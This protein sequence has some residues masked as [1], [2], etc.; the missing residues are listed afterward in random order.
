MC[1]PAAE[2]FFCVFFSQQIQTPHSFSTCFPDGKMF[3]AGQLIS[4]TAQVLQKFF[5]GRCVFDCTVNIP[6]D[7]LIPGRHFLFLSR[8]CFPVAML[9]SSVSLAGAA[10]LPGVLLCRGAALCGTAA[11]IAFA[12][13][14]HAF[15][16]SLF[17]AGLPALV[18]LPPLLIQWAEGMCFS[19]GLL[20]PGAAGPV[21]GWTGV[22][23]AF[24]L[25][26]VA[27]IVCVLLERTAIPVLVS[28]V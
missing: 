23:A 28:L 20:R 17:L 24:S 3:S 16:L 14:E 26:C 15:F 13:S 10:L 25:A 9:L 21:G 8:L 18:T 2:H 11:H 19:R 12:A 6:F 1:D 27:A 4:H 5:I 22:A 7:P